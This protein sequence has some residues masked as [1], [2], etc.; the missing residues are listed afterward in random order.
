[1]HVGVSGIEPG[2]SRSRVSAQPLVPPLPTKS[3][4]PGQSHQ[5][6]S[7]GEAIGRLLYKTYTLRVISRLI[8]GCWLVAG[9]TTWPPRLQDPSIG[10]M[11]QPDIYDSSIRNSI[12][13]ARGKVE[14]LN[15]RGN[16]EFCLYQKSLLK[17]TYIS[18][19][20]NT[21]LHTCEM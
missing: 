19:L 17:I 4:H 21:N 14:G 3:K 7:V 16:L 5:Y 13:Q 11:L 10:Q 6:S 2:S 1:M 8:W 9:V 15:P 18:L 12:R 20:W